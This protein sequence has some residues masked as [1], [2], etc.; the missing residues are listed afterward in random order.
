MEQ[1]QSS[2]VAIAQL[3]DAHNV[4]FDNEDFGEIFVEAAGNVGID[5][6]GDSW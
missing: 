4:T 6:G 5:T 2:H 1:G 3:A